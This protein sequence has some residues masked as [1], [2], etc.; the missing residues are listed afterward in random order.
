[1]STAVRPNKLINPYNQ[2][3]ASQEIDPNSTEYN[4][5]V[6]ETN[7]VENIEEELNNYEEEKEEK[8]NEQ[9]IRENYEPYN[10]EAANKIIQKSVKRSTNVQN[11]LSDVDEKA[12][13]IVENVKN[14]IIEQFKQNMRQERCT[15]YGI[16]CSE[17]NVAPIVGTRYKCTIWNSYNLCELCEIN[18]SHDHVFIKVRESKTRIPL[19]SE[20]KKM[21]KKIP[22]E[23]NKKPP[24]KGW[25]RLD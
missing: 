8:S 12:Q 15:H 11:N 6:Q 9:P 14:I 7:S 22:K 3:E 2:S 4:M 20:I 17:W 18:N 13:E 23:E 16:T 25:H 10:E 5:D 24:S 1:M 19:L 21:T